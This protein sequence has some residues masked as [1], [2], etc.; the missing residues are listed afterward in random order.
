MTAFT[1]LLNAA[2]THRVALIAWEAAVL[3]KDL[4]ARPGNL[5]HLKAAAG[6]RPPAA[7]AAGAEQN[8]QARRVTLSSPPS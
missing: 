2:T 1:L 4:A 6:K 5:P 7:A 3:T 8:P